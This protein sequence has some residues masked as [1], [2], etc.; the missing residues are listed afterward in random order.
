[1]VEILDGLLPPLVWRI[2]IIVLEVLA[3]VLP[4]L[5]AV[6]Y[7]TYAE[8]KVIAA[9]LMLAYISIPA[10]ILIGLLKL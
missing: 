2:A 7:L 3:I 9:I 6:A 8:R 1:M 4:M 10:T 5:L